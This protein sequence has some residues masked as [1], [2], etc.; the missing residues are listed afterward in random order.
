MNELES[1]TLQ[2]N[3]DSKLNALEKTFLENA[4]LQSLAWQ[5]DFD[6]RLLALEQLKKD[7]SNKVAMFENMEDAKQQSLAWQAGCDRRLLTLEQHKEDY[8]NKGAMF[9]DMEDAKQQSL[10]WQAGFDRRLLTLEQ[11]KQDYSNKVVPLE[12]RLSVIEEC[13]ATLLELGE[14]KG[15]EHTKKVSLFQDR[16]SVIEEST[17]NFLKLSESNDQQ[18]R[19]LKEEV[20]K[21]KI[22]VCEIEENLGLSCVPEA[23]DPAHVEQKRHNN[24][25]TVPPEDRNDVLS[26]SVGGIS[27]A[28]DREHLLEHGPDKQIKAS[29][30]TTLTHRLCVVECHIDMIASILKHIEAKFS[31][32]NGQVLTSSE[33]KSKGERVMRKR[34]AGKSNNSRDTLWISQEARESYDKITM[35]DQH[36]QMQLMLAR[37]SKH[38]DEAVPLDARTLSWTCS[39]IIEESDTAAEMPTN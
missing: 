33:V 5:A 4:K 38:L 15:Q 13:I 18:H 1:E 21:L 19:D 36:S 39:T 6:G 17:A 28:H 12:E 30:T 10:A 34:S 24:N 2:V 3:L 8:A 22:I 9:E 7:Y 25:L 31:S 29:P 32:L 37:A 35:K 27:L 14:V 11:H 26:K 23:I 16:L 20:A